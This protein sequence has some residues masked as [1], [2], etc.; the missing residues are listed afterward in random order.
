M[1]VTEIHIRSIWSPDYIADG[2]LGIDPST[3]KATGVTHI[4]FDLDD[5]LARRRD[6]A[7]S[8]GYLQFVRS[9]QAAD[10]NVL[11]ATN[12]PRNISTLTKRLNAEAVHPKGLSR[13]PLR[14]FYKRVIDK[15]GAAPDHIVMI[16]NHIL[17]DIVGANRAGMTTVLVKPLR[18]RLSLAYRFYAT[19]ARIHG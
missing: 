18:P 8:P 16:G 12:T 11:I 3:L 4:V 15:S 1:S 19:Y 9:L 10:F 17:N 5:T 13:K 14:S 2:I 6:S 7:I